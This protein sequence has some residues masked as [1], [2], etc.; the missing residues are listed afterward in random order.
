MRRFPNT[1]TGPKSA[2]VRAG[3]EPG[4]VGW[5]GSAWTAKQEVAK[6]GVASF[7]NTVAG[8]PSL[9]D[10]SVESAGPTHRREQFMTAAFGSRP[11]S[12]IAG[13]DGG[14]SQ[15]GAGT[16]P[17]TAALPSHSAPHAQTYPV[18]A[19]TSGF[20]AISHLT[21]AK[22]ARISTMLH[23]HGSTS[24][25]RHQC[26]HTV[27]GTMTEA[28]EEAD[29]FASASPRPKRDCRTTDY[30]AVENHLSLITDDGGAGDQTAM[31]T[32]LLAVS[33]CISLDMDLE[34]ALEQVILETGPMLEAELVLSYL[35]DP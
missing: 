21:T 12:A 22:S 14:P 16:L 18:G 2:A 3:R 10:R 29:G 7:G 34:N 19:H 32:E 33:S 20:Y 30:T 35:V 11:G 6:M 8:S 26:A 5:S 31:R 23:Q 27:D 28:A 9:A 1:S 15:S 24:A 25:G 17:R 13:G 4:G